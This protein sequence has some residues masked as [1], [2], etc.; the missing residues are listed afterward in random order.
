M[1]TFFA[2]ARCNG[3]TRRNKG[4]RV[5]AVVEV[6]DIDVFVIL[7]V[8]AREL[9]GRAARA[10]ASSGNLELCATDCYRVRKYPSN[11][12]LQSQKNATYCRTERR[13]ASGRHVKPAFQ[14]ATAT[15]VSKTFTF[16][17]IVRLTRYSPLLS[18][19]GS[20]N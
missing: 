1:T 19:V 9:D 8:C 3:P 16:T 18:P 10:A 6:G 11:G 20:L 5:V 14:T 7:I 2:A 13:Q 4:S 15:L 17:L 12:R